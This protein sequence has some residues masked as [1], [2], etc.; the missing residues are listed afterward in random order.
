MNIIEE[1]YRGNINPQIKVFNKDS[2]YAD[3]INILSDNEEKLN[4]CLGGEEKR[5]LSTLIDAQG[6]ILSIECRENFIQG[7][8]LGAKFMLDTFLTFRY[9]PINDEL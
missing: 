6:E 8:K 2:Q 7:W 5:L 3:F 9:C 1:L 4:D